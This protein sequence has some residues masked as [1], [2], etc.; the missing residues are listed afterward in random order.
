MEL[1][2]YGT[3]SLAVTSGETKLLF[4]PFLP[5]RG[6]SVKTRRSDYDGYPDVLVTHGHLDHIGSLPELDVAGRTVWCTET[7]AETLR[8]KG[9]ENVSVIAPGQTLTFGEMSVTVYRGKHIRFDA[10]TVLKTLFNVRM[11]KY[12]GNLPALLRENRIC[13]E[14]GE[15]AAFLV[16]AEG[17]SL[18]VMGSLNL[19]C[20]EE[21]P[22]DADVLVLPYQGASRLCERSLAFIE[23]LRPRAVFL[24][25]FDDTFPPI[26][27]SI[28]TSDIEKALAGRLPVIRP[29]YG[30]A[31]TV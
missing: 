4:D 20:D 19:D 18:F 24:D 15:T 10:P 28:D 27:G 2:W 29:E 11:L 5:L 30:R 16:R 12:A 8:G 7:P 21:Y 31:Y 26:S 6:S 13:R 3:A 1:R 14:N 25:H 9:V 17:R 23:R 22:T